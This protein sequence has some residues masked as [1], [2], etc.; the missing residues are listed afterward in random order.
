M[1]DFK[2]FDTQNKSIES[3]E[4]PHHLSRRSVGQS[5]S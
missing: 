3:H 2:M 4:I 5:K 1:T